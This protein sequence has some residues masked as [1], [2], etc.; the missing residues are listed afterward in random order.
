MGSLNLLADLVSW[1]WTSKFF[2][3]KCLLFTTYNKSEN[4]L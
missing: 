2:V 1:L 3:N 4:I